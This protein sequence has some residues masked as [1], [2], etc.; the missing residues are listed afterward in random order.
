M[1]SI[2]I[3]KRGLAVCAVLGAAALIGCG[4]GG[5]GTSPHIDV[6]HRTR[7]GPAG[8]QPE[9]DYP[10]SGRRSIMRNSCP[11]AGTN[12]GANVVLYDNTAGI[13]VDLKNPPRHHRRPLRVPQHR[14]HSC[15][16]LHGHQGHHRADDAAF[17]GRRDDRNRGHR[18]YHPAERCRRPPD[19]HRHLQ[20]PQNVHRHRQHA[21][22]RLQSG[23]LHCD[24]QQS[25]AGDRGRRHEHLRRSEP[26]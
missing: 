18:R 1:K 21:G 4:G 9:E 6:R 19:S 7:R 20:G 2:E 13:Q 10:M 12:G 8:G 5:R 23:A 11:P 22:R 3:I 16:H 26:P 14:D 17:Q 25:S 24:R 15:R